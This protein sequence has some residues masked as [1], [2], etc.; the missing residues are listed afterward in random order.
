MNTANRSIIALRCQFV[1]FVD[2]YQEQLCG[3]EVIWISNTV[4]SPINATAYK[5]ALHK[6]GQETSIVVFDANDTLEMNALGAISGCIRGNGALILLLPKN[7][8]HYE[9]SLFYQRLLRVLSE[10]HVQLHQQHPLTS[11]SKTLLSIKPK[12]DKKHTTLIATP[13]QS[14]AIS[15]IKKVVTGHRK[16]PLVIT[17]NRGR[18]KSSAIGMAINEILKERSIKIIICAP[19]K[20][21]VAP[22][23]QCAGKHSNL[24]YVAADELVK[25][26]PGA[27]LVIID[28]AGAIPVPLLS[29][30][31]QHYSRMVFSTT[32]HGYE[33]NGRGF[34]IRFHDQLHRYTPEWRSVELKKPIRWGENDPVESFTN[35]LL[36]LNSEPAELDQLAVTVSGRLVY[37][38][39]KPHELLDNEALLRQLFGLLVIA[40]YQTRP[41]DL[42]QLLDQQQISIHALFSQKALIAVAIVS[43]EGGL[44]EALAHAIYQGTRR[45][46]GH[47]VP[48]ILLSQMGILEASTLH[49]DRIMRIA[50]HPNCRRQ[51]LASRLLTIIASHSSADYL[52]TSFGLSQDLLE[53]WEKSSYSPVYL[54]QKREASSGYYSAVLV[55]ALS[56]NG[57]VLQEAAGTSFAK[58]LL[59]QL[60]DTHRQLDPELS[61]KLLVSSQQGN[62]DLC[63]Q[64]I[65]DIKRFARAQCGLESAIAALKHWLPTALRDDK[66]RINNNE[67]KL[68]IMRILQHHSWQ[69]CCE[70]LGIHGKQ[71]AQQTLQQTISVLADNLLETDVSM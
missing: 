17:S 45:P 8:K 41:S 1:G 61:F 33:G 23:F 22:L 51:Q 21:M 63:Q 52:S 12:P 67:A 19:A 59:A 44:D 27:G 7:D 35:D 66:Q 26:L 68:L 34:A 43:H 24:S 55:H 49:T 39:L 29:A 2:Q 38:Q 37:K 3:L 64:E 5:Q 54:G 58:T 69:T 9:T 65:R 28:E 47:L 48:Q 40:H 16:R 56:N 6:L 32:L 70:S 13:E 30:L 14:Q 11:L 4:T 25:E 53:F 18:G 36:L 57:Q 46:K 10:H 15:A 42:L 60:S 31:L 50:T 20:A 62:A 71:I